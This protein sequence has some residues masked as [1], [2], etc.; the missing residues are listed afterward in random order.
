[1]EEHLP[2]RDGRELQRQPP[3]RADRFTAATSSG[4]ERWQLLN[5]LYEATPTTGWASISSEY[6][7]ERA[8]ESR[9]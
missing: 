1:M 8:N 9:R 5:S 3:R 7:I 2:R 6:P 4:T